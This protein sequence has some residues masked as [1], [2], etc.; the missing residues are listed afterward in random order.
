[1]H[2]GFETRSPLLDHEV[3]E[4][5]AALPVSFKVRHRTGKY[6]LKRLAGKY[7]PPGF[8]ARRKMGFSIPLAEWLRGTLRP[9]VEEVLADRAAMAPLDASTIREVAGELFEACV[10]HSS[11][12]WSLLMYGLW[13][14]SN[15]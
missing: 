13:R 5:C 15:R 1:M 9:M 10:D 12:I 2:C 4:F 6:L 7:L 3:I 8:T 11:R 14:R